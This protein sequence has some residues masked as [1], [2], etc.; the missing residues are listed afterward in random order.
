MK[1]VEH[2]A[3]DGMHA[4]RSEVWEIADL[5]ALRAALQRLAATG[6]RAT[7]RAAGLS[8]DAQALGD[9][10]T[11]RLTPEGFG[12][13]DPVRV[14]GGRATVRLG[15]MAR[16]GDVFDATL[17]RGYLPPNVVTGSEITVG[18][19]LSSDCLS[20]FSGA[21]GKEAEAIDSVEVMTP[22]G[23]VHVARRDAPE[24]SLARRLF[25]AVVGGFGA[26]G[27]VVGATYR[28]RRVGRRRPWAKTVFET[29][30]PRDFSW[31]ALLARVR[32]ETLAAR[33][34][35]RA[36][37]PRAWRGA[38]PRGVYD[39]VSATAWFPIYGSPR[40]LLLRSRHVTAPGRSTTLL[41]RG[42]TRT[43][44]LG[45]V[46]LAHAT[47]GDGTQDANRILCNRRPE[48]VDD[49]D[50]FSFFM[51]GNAEAR[52]V[53]AARS[54]HVL[55]SLQQTFVLPEEAAEGFAQEAEA[56]MAGRWPTILDVLH[57]PADD[58]PV[59]L[60]PT[61]GLGGF[62]ITLAWQTLDG[63]RIDG[64]RALVR[65]LSRRCADA[66]GRVSLVKNV[67]APDAVVRGMYAEGISE[68]RA[69]K[70]EVDPRGVLGGP[71]VD[72]LLGDDQRPRARRPR[73]RE[74]SAPRGRRSSA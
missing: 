5:A 37:G 23:V 18:G 25:S 64:A 44:V 57:L 26:F 7:V 32:D 46:A 41:Y 13:I 72:R 63:R 4:S 3:Y 27:V 73:A 70:R 33:R 56:R 9:D 55:T 22:D 69:L 65:L 12:E 51:D 19:S 47:L 10:V 48:S 1:R 11:L 28:L 58:A 68:A 49:L 42:L 54:A 74:V 53:V 71:F 30:H 8:L 43:R 16:W 20:R 34:A 60:S 14:A 62:A 59:L 17:P 66:G 35:V 50:A 38:L 52:H 21:W 67:Y 29:F 2:V 15:A 40:G 6:R 39:A 24:G 45:E 61:R 31:A 36:C